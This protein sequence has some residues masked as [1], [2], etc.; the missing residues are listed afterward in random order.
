LGNK[1]DTNNKFNLTI[2]KYLLEPTESENYNEKE[3]GELM[4]VSA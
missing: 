3:E 1:E 4:G 2:L